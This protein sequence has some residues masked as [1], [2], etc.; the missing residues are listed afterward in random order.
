MNDPMLLPRRRLLA[1]LAATAGAAL[2]GPRLVRAATG[3]KTSAAPIR[4]VP[5]L[6]LYT[7]GLKPSDDLAARFKEVAAV[8]YREVEFP[9]HYQK[10]AAELRRAL[11]AAKL[12][13]PA[14]HASPRPSNGAWDLE[15]DLSR[16]IADMKTLGAR[17]A[18]ASIPRLPDRIY[19]VLQHPP[20]GFDVAAVSKLF[21]SLEADDW[22]RSADLLNEKGALLA[23]H[24]LRIA[25]HNHGVDF[26]PLP[27]DTNGF[28]ILVERTDPKL[29][30]FE[31]DIGWAVSARQELPA[32]FKLLGDRVKLIHLKDTR[33]PSDLVMELASTDAGTGI[34][35]WDEFADLVRHS[36]VEHL[37]V[38]QEEPFPTTP[39]DAI[40]ID[41]RFLTALFAGHNDGAKK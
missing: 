41:Y 4:W 19:D 32:L 6:Q 18:V 11:D 9:G 16:L 25:H 2:A 38:E 27:G 22:K 39:M 8:G 34:V 21:S 37:F 35:K 31:L 10:S 40:K 29:V 33:H 7:L 1:L 28:R 13:A 12:T 15:G 5:G 30:D 23:R 17:Y 3:D 36:R 14:I 20:T 24:G 26:L